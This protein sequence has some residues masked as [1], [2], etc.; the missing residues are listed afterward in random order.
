MSEINVQ[1]AAMLATLIY[2]PELKTEWQ[3]VATTN[4]KCT[5]EELITHSEIELKK[6]A[7]AA[8]FGGQ[9]SKT[10]FYDVFNKIKS[11]EKIMSLEIENIENNDQTNFRAMTL[12]PPKTE[13]PPNSMNPI[14]VFHPPA[15]V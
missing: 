4:G 14:I 10:E 15:M 1:E 8:T 12:I 2:R 13:N 7:E 5:V 9:M 3:E 6:Q 11:S